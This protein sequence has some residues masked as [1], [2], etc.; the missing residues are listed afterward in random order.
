MIRARTGAKNRCRT[1]GPPEV[2]MGGVMLLGS[3]GS[4]PAPAST[5]QGQ[6][7]A[8]DHRAHHHHHH[9]DHHDRHRAS[10]H[11]L[12]SA[13]LASLLVARSMADTADPW[14]V[15][16]RRGSQWSPFAYGYTEAGW[17]RQSTRW[18]FP[19]DARIRSTMKAASCRT[20]PRSD[21]PS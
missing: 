13:S 15:K 10:A 21:E 8:D 18:R 9:H 3:S 17:A 16:R 7:R 11:Q 19:R 6:A 20:K 14:V 4:V 12:A 1:R 5:H 2:V